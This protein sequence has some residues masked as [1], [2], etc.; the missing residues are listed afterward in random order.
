MIVA[1]GE[2]DR[3]LDS[4]PDS[5][6]ESDC[7]EELVEVEVEVEVVDIDGDGDS[8]KNSDSGVCTIFLDTGAVAG[9]GLMSGGAVRAYAGK[10]IG[11]ADAGSVCHSAS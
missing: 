11:E 8:V 10:Y 9:L 5:D 2:V 3:E 6:S 7:E 4:D 1:Q